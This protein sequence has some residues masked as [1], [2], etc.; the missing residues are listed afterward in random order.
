MNGPSHIETCYVS[1]Y[2]SIRPENLWLSANRPLHERICTLGGE[3]LFIPSLSHNG[4]GH[5]LGKTHDLFWLAPYRQYGFSGLAVQRLDPMSR[6]DGG[7]GAAH[8]A[9]GLAEPSASDLTRP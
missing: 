1:V 4:L 3:W 7:A 6:N 8:D 2:R 5:R 9:K